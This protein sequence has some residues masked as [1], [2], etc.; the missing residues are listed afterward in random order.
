MD[1]N[2]SDSNN[3]QNG[4][5]LENEF[6][7]PASVFREY[8]IRGLANS[9][10]TDGFAKC[11]GVALGELALSRNQQTFFV[12]RD[13]RL[14]SPSLAE[15]LC[16]GLE[17]AGCHVLS[18]G[19][20][21]TPILNFAIDRDLSC[22]SGV[23]VTASHNA[24]AYNGFK[25]IIGGEVISG[26]ELQKLKSALKPNG[27]PFKTSTPRITKD[28]I[29]QYSQRIVDDSC[30]DR[31]FNLVID[32]GNSVAGPIAVDLFKRLG[33]SV[34]PLYCDVDGSFPNHEPNPSDEKNLQ[35]LIAKV[36]STGAD[37]GFAFDGDGDRLVVISASGSIVWPDRL[38]MIFARDLLG[39]TPGGD[40]VFDVKSTMRLKELIIEHKG[41]PTIC[42]TGH[43]H[44][45]KAV[46]DQNALIGGEF[47]GHIFFND[48]WGGFD[49]GLYA[50][51]RLLEVLCQQY[52]GGIKTLD[53]IV[54][55]FKASSYSPEILVPVDEDKKFALMDNLQN[56]CIFDGAK[57]VRLDGMR[58]EYSGG[59]GLVRASN[60]TPNLT[61]RFEADDHIQLEKIKTQ[62]RK[63]LGPFIN[64]LEDYI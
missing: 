30:I 47:S 6:L 13:A 49:D 18:L 23:M 38:M 14:S 41:L 57:I 22:K 48:R 26:R 50:G 33:C 25:I 54:S 62:F 42:K 44:I 39:K 12:G 4:L 52:N 63:Q 56:N 64:H 45:R 40:V 37:L 27:F 17:S 46:Q 7:A 53:E 19:E 59:W 32:A 51:M 36:I 61:L 21:T 2:L 31:P 1:L 10:I 11:L 35:D 28:I 5:S 8:D 15:S 16:T 20:V 60:T 34:E 55:E 24:A 43:S 29:S 9:E 3:R 58:V